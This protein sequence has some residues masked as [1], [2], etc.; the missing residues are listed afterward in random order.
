MYLHCIYTFNY[1]AI[2]T[3]YVILPSR[4]KAMFRYDLTFF[5]LLT[6]EARVKKLHKMCRH[7][8]IGILPWFFVYFN[9]PLH[10][11]NY[12]KYLI[13]CEVSL[14]FFLNVT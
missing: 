4:Y 10:N 7:N 2:Y 14:M 12:L 13:N 11:P 8:E 5:I 3:N 9:T 6:A 1:D